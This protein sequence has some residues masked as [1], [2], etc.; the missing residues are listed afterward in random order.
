MTSLPELV[1]CSVAD[2]WRRLVEQ[3]DEL[4]CDA[5]VV[6]DLVNIRYL[7]G[8]TGSNATLVV[9]DEGMVFMTDGRY[10]TQAADQLAS[11]G[12]ADA[13]IDTIIA[14]DVTDALRASVAGRAGVGVE[15]D[16]ITWS[17]QQRWSASALA[18]V[19]MVSTDGV[20]LAQRSVK[21]AGEISRLHRASAIADAALAAIETRLHDGLTERAFARELEAAMTDLGSDGPSFETIVAS[22]PNGARPHHRPGDRVIGG[23]GRGADA[24]VP[25]GAGELVVIDFGATVDGYHS[26]MTRTRVVG[27]LSDTQIEMLAVVESAQAAGRA[28]V[29]AGVAGRAVDAVCRDALDQAG[30]GSY[31]THGTGHGIGLVIHESPRLSAASDDTLCAGQCVTV[32]PGVYHPD[33]G[34]V[35]VEDSVVVTDD[36][37]RL[38]T[39]APY[40]V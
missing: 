30:W 29:R 6:T 33:H 12:T 25:A 24:E 38:L 7:T 21:D 37:C 22:G 13:V 35:R 32:E 36:G 27:A 11:A 2:R 20:L 9:T 1:A 16:H 34:G 4:G 39:G 5:F 18:D 10:T 15:A 40:R 26:D 3:F 23:G 19:A 17:T 8:F 31:F 14:N 28:A